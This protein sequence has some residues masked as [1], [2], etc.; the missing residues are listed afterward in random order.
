MQVCLKHFVQAYECLNYG[1]LLVSLII[2]FGNSAFSCYVFYNKIIYQPSIYIYL[3]L[4]KNYYCKPK[5]CQPSVHQISLYFC[6]ME[7]IRMLC[8][9]LACK[10]GVTPIHCNR[11]FLHRSILIGLQKL[12][13]VK[14]TVE[15]ACKHQSKDCPAR[16]MGCRSC[17]QMSVVH[18]FIKAGWHCMHEDHCMSLY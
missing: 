10:R 2:Q 14:R 16:T 17:L 13:N 7:L 11:T 18:K 8:S 4:L 12:L 15:N 3:Q 6:S 5:K 1:D 9:F